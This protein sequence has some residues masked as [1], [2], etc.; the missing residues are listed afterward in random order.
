[1]KILDGEGAGR[2]AMGRDLMCIGKLAQRGN[3]RSWIH[4]SRDVRGC[5]VADPQVSSVR[6]GHARSYIRSQTPLVTLV[7]LL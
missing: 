5:L 4:F 2:A 1:M 3:I 6:D 7:E